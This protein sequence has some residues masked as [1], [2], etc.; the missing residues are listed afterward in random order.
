LHETALADVLLPE[1][2]AAESV[3]GPSTGPRALAQ[4]PPPA[5]GGRLAGSALSPQTWSRAV[6]VLREMTVRR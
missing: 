5:A 2:P 6:Q 3:D 1:E 4:L